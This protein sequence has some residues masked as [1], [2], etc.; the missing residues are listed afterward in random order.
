M[1]TMSVLYAMHCFV[2]YPRM[3]NISHNL[4]RT[5]NIL[6]QFIVLTYLR[7]VHMKVDKTRAC[8]NQYEL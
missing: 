7:V 1:E 4:N 3:C 2:N 5:D 8:L 6:L